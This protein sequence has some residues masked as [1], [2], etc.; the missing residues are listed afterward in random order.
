MRF[1]GI[2]GGAG[3]GKSEI[4]QFIKRNYPAYI[5][6]A[7][8]LAHELMQ[9]QTACYQNIKTAFPSEDIF[10]KD[11]CLDRKKLAE[12][13]F[14]DDKKREEM[15]RIV[16]PAVKQEIIKRVDEERKKKKFSYF[17]LEAALL[18]EEG[19][20][21]ICDELW[22]IDT[23]EDLRRRRLKSSRGYSDAKIDAVFGSQLSKEEYQKHC[24][25]VIDNNGSLEETFAQIIRA[26]EGEAGNING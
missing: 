8:N 5:L 2:T 24:S 9:P 6:L 23:S 14:A 15:N 17:I 10:L 25:V 19:Y 26:F 11:G 18:I 20:D 3:A 21:K 22:Y 7:D 1:I 12:V 13:I 16:H 4:L